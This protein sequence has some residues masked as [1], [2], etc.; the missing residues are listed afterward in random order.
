MA[1]QHDRSHDEHVQILDACQRGD[2]KDAVR[3]LRK[4]IE[5]TQKEVQGYFRNSQRLSKAS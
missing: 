4:H 2:V 3:L 1:A 5:Q